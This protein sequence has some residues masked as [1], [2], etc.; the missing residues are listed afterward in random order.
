MTG[1]QRTDADRLD[2]RNG[3]HRAL[4]EAFG[5]AGVEFSSCHVDDPGDG[6][7]VLVPPEVPK[8][9]LVD[10]L[11]R[12]LADALARHNEAAGPGT[13]RRM[14]MAVHAGEVTSVVVGRPDDD[15]ASAPTPSR[16]PRPA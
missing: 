13:A 10:L 16:R 7:L 2:V 1:R 8:A 9:T 14:R 11:P 15:W 12:A 4:R 3:M 5:T 6:V